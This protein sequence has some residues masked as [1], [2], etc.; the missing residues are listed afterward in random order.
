MN[1]EPLE[2]KILT[3]TLA[4]ILSTKAELKAQQ[5]KIVKLQI[6]DI[7]I[8]ISQ[9]YFNND[10]SQNYIVFQPIQKN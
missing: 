7:S 2:T 1:R 5:D 6:D 8:F 3:L 4:K 10:E 9:S